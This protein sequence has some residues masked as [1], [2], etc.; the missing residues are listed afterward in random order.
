TL[1]GIL[2]EDNGNIEIDEDILS[3]ATFNANKSRIHYTKPVDSQGV[4]VFIENK[5]GGAKI[6]AHTIIAEILSIG[7]NEIDSNKISYTNPVTNL[8][9]IISENELSSIRV[10][11][12]LGQVIMEAKISAKTEIEIETSSWNSGM[13]FVT[14]ETSEGD[15]GQIK[16]IKK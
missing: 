3:A 15:K 8:L 13:Y 2:L 9:S 12:I 4:V 16:V 6:Y 1:G 10:V 7:D 11:S 14:I 5:G